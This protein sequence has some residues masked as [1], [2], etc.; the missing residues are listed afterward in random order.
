MPGAEKH[1]GEWHWNYAIYRPSF[2]RGWLSISA[3]G[4]KGKLIFMVKH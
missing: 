4:Q 2:W 3:R 1:K